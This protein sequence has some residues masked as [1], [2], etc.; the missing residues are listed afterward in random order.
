MTSD[1]M[2]RN[3]KIAIT[4]IALK[5]PEADDLVTLR[6]NLKSGRDSV[7]ELS[8]ERRLR[9]S[10]P[11]DEPYLPN[12]YLDGID[13]FDYQFFEIPRGQ[14]NLL[15]PEHRLVLQSA[16]Q[17]LEQAGIAPA[18]VRGKRVGV[19]VGATRIDYAALAERVEAPLVMGVH[20]AAVAGRVSQMLG[21]RG[22]SLM[23][24]SSCSSGL[25]AVKQAINDLTLFNTELA[26]VSGANINL[27]GDPLEDDPLNLGIRSHDGK[28]R[29]F[30]VDADGTGSGEAVIT[31]VLRRLDDALGD[32][33]PILAVLRSVAVNSV[34]DRSSSFTAPDSRS[35]AEVISLAWDEAGLDPATA[36]YV[37]AHGTG[38][39]L[40]DPI[41]AEALGTVF[42]PSHRD[43][44]L[45]ISTIKS[46]IG[47]TWS[48]AGLCGL[49]KATLAVHHAE[50]Y[51]SVHAEQLS[52]LIDFQQAGLEV[53][54]QYRPWPDGSGP[55]RAGVS[56]FGITGTGAHAVL[57]ELTER[58]SWP[59]ESPQRQT[60]LPVSGRSPEALTANIEAIRAWIADNPD[61]DRV[62]V[63]R[64]LVAGRDH[65]AHRAILHLEDPEVVTSP[66][67]LTS[68]SAE[69][70]VPSLALLV[71]SQPAP[72]PTTVAAFRAEPALNRCYVEAEA[73]I[74]STDLPEN[75]AFCLQY[76]I[77][78]WFNDIGMNV[79]HIITEGRGRAARD[80]ADGRVALSEAV[81]HAATLP[82]E[83]T[84]ADLAPR[85]DRMLAHFSDQELCWVELG[86]PSPISEAITARA[87]HVRFIAASDGPAELL[88]QLYLRG[89]TW[90]WKRS[91]GCGPRL[92]MPGYQ[93]ETTRCW[94]RDAE[95]DSAAVA[96]RR[97]IQTVEPQN[98]EE[99]DSTARMSTANALGAVL[100]AWE[101]AL[102]E[103]VDPDADFIEI[104]GD[105]IS[106][107]QIVARLVT[108][109]GA[110]L[111][112]LDL[113]ELGTPQAI[114]EKLAGTATPPTPQQAPTASDQDTPPEH[115]EL[116]R[117]PAS[118]AQRS[119]WLASQLRGG[120][121]A[122]NLTRC[123]AV[124]G[125]LDEAAL[126]RA[127]ELVIK[128]H[129]ALR[130]SFVMEES[131]LVQQ[132]HPGS[133]VHPP[134]LDIIRLD[135]PMP[136][137]PADIDQLIQRAS[138]PFDLASAPLLRAQWYQFQG[139]QSFLLV[140]IHHLVADGWSLAII[141]RDLWRYYA[142]AQEHDPISV[143]EPDLDTNVTPA[144]THDLQHDKS[145]R[146]YWLNQF[147]EVPEP[148]SL[149][150]SSAERHDFR[151][152]YVHYQLPQELWERLSMF[153][154]QRGV[155]PFLTCLSLMAS[156][157][158]TYCDG[159]EMVLGTSLAGRDDPASRDEV[160]MRVKTVPIRFSIRSDDTL[161][162]LV[163]NVRASFFAA[164]QHGSYD[165]ESLIADLK[166][167]QALS[168]PDLFE[169]LI[170]YQKFG[171]GQHDEGHTT[172]IGDLRVTP[173]EL[174]LNTSVFPLN[175]M[176]GESE[177]TL[178]AVV[179][180]DT[181][182]FSPE[183]ID[184]LWRSFCHVVEQAVA[185]PAITLGAIELLSESDAASTR[186][187]GYRRVDVDLHMPIHQQIEYHA[188]V[189]PNTVAL[190]RLDDP[191][192]R[193]TFT[194]LN[195]RANQVARLLLEHHDVAPGDLVALAMD[196]SVPMVIA[197][198]AVWK[199]GAAYL[200]LDPSNPVEFTQMLLDSANSHLVL[201]EPSRRDAV[202]RPS[203]GLDVLILDH[204][205]AR[206]Q[207]SVNLNLA[208]D[209]HSLA[210][211]IYTSGSTGAPKGAMVEH[212]GMLNH[213]AAK[214]IDL[215]LGPETVIPQTASNSFD[216]SLWQMFAAPYSGGQTI[217]VPQ[218]LQ[219]DPCRFGRRA[220]DAGI[221]VLEV[222]PSYLDA[223]LD[224]WQQEE[225]WPELSA[226]RWLM[227]TGEACSPLQVNRWLQHYPAIPVINAYGPTE[228]SDDVTHHIMARPVTTSDVPIG[229][230]IPNT[231]ITIRNKQLQLLPAGAVGEICVSGICVGR[232]YL[233][234]PGQTQQSFVE[235]PASPG[236]RMYRTGDQ[237]YW[238][239]D[240]TLHY[241]GRDDSQVK[242]RGFR[243]S[244]DEIERRILHLPGVRK[245]AL[246][247]KRVIGASHDHMTAYV[248]LAGWTTPTEIHDT[249]AQQLASHMLP[250]QFVAMDEL[251]LT[252][253]GKID[254]KL[255]ATLDDIASDGEQSAPETPTE[256]TLASIVSSILQREHIGID[257]R[258]FEI[259]GDSLK[260]IRVVARARTTFEVP[261]G[262]DDIFA[263]QTIHRLAAL[264]DSQSPDG[265]SSSVTSLGGPGEYVVAPVQES[266]LD[267]EGRYLPQQRAAFNR[268][269]QFMITGPLDHALLRQAMQVMMA[270]HETLRST[271]DTH[272]RLQI[273]HPA[274]AMDPQLTVHD[275]QQHLDS[276]TELERLVQE[277]LLNPFDI[278]EEPLVRADLFTLAPEQHVLLT[279]MHQLISDAIS[280]GVFHSELQRI[281]ECLVEN[282]AVDLPPLEVQYKE[283][284]L[285]RRNHLAGRRPE[286]E[287]Y[288]AAYL[289][290][291][292]PR[293]PLSKSKARPR[294]A[295]LRGHRLVSVVPDDLTAGL[296]AL[297]QRLGVTD[298]IVAET[299]IGQMLLE[300]TGRSEV[301]MGTYTSGRL[302][303]SSQHQIGC[304][305]SAIPRRFRVNSGPISAFLQQNQRDL[306]T[307]VQ[308]AELPYADSLA[309]LQWVRGVD[310]TPQFDVMI[311]YDTATEGDLTTAG[312][313][314]T[315]TAVP[316]P[317]FAKE[318]GVHIAWVRWP[319]RLEIAI[320]Y[321]DDLFT[322]SD[323]HDLMDA[324]Y[325]SME[326]LLN[327]ANS[328]AH[329]Q[330]DQHV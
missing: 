71:T 297:S 163:R 217:V 310:S 256:K 243:I 228:A 198:L 120:S 76:A 42:G 211:V 105:S 320:T 201:T 259:G 210:Y 81:H 99:P 28:T 129:P 275:L 324:T 245:A 133:V 50:L 143:P 135:T 30:A 24:D 276:Q 49:V 130:T 309:A 164:V 230:P 302:D 132:V 31:V 213:L 65:H 185:T 266:L 58:P 69:D 148:M 231:W 150:R 23:I 169:V 86:A 260:A 147:S 67:P 122:F 316:L 96:A 44:A 77:L 121:E 158:R 176:F 149:P 222:V 98:A 229:T 127:L 232:G 3:P 289:D 192:E 315:F 293:T 287:S 301:L 100:R 279:A 202:P 300:K 1:R 119:I 27:C 252:P 318:G 53:T 248:V 277:R 238:G 90:D 125:H 63:Q 184:V 138:Q 107:L 308:H 102:G 172:T 17:A 257:D 254:R 153:A 56:S 329:T 18:A 83:P 111:D 205:T 61:A 22:P 179:R 88:G 189:S 209:P 296:S 330:E 284:A 7:R 226:L 304:Y 9:T 321:T 323:I 269:D 294:R 13:E 298:F 33:D 265:G 41:E 328:Q 85:V 261:I 139:G 104:G 39:Q 167:M 6:R 162:Q 233:N 295:S 307:A 282:R 239:A 128:R 247:L 136:A 11:L 91:V 110:D 26:L 140:S 225:S 145:D 268:N 258:F 208:F 288:W 72:D 154:K 87:Q 193:L 92:T 171:I 283:T 237:G 244:L 5:L 54:R 220:N 80:A 10:Q 299:V 157:L 8:T 314:A 160:G 187:I 152:Q 180:F 170:E 29:A 241:L 113:F 84:P 82:T 219:L 221:T 40:G 305:A 159:D 114:A 57:E 195:A 273:V 35:E 270:R 218:A 236:Q 151:G 186:E 21:L 281:Y 137:A 267:I 196:R 246:V 223:M 181:S 216:I 313:G 78:R 214:I 36:A 207:S 311:S 109:T 215:K 93:F 317:R 73:E 46:N 74:R 25:V 278:A 306:V 197:I 303:L 262:L 75:P 326:R 118:A 206:D 325:R 38:T 234:A 123:F 116:H 108:E 274:G 174:T 64:T 66:Q 89:I 271:F 272:R 12:G 322:A 97:Q 37:E 115:T 177:Q 212:A 126:R 14:A 117:A 59:A 20:Q 43:T 253:N 161:D 173:V 124:N 134:Q 327:H 292:E 280:A 199:C 112:V 15:S 166:E 250:A 200:P 312:G 68:S 47:H 188:A 183:M 144:S 95:L 224:A 55:R 242:V 255:L 156:A 286:L 249:L 101:D 227:V 106:G 235:D 34:A 103:P 285:S 264:I 290:G 131:G 240:G 70:P 19:Y 52:P 51:P 194:Q 60:W 178:G 62:A 142:D 146:E 165:Y 251:P 141:E 32:G 190:S 182:R 203:K 319:D 155:T 94:L 4:G 191:E 204:D 79:T 263:H 175:I 48:A 291:A 168:R 16:Y 2:E 45:Q